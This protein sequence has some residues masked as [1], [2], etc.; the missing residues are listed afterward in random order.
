MT[1]RIPRRQSEAACSAGQEG[2]RTTAPWSS[3]AMCWSIPQR[4]LV[5]DVEVIGPSAPNLH[6][7]SPLEHTDFFVRLCDVEPSGRSL[8]LCDG[9]VRLDAGV[10]ASGTP[11]ALR[12]SRCAS[13]RRRTS[14]GAGTGIRAQVLERRAPRFARNLGGGDPLAT[15][16]TMHVADQEVW[17]DPDH[18][19]AIVLPARDPGSSR[20][21]RDSMRATRAGRDALRLEPTS[22]RR[23]CSWAIPPRGRRHR[24]G[25]LDLAHAR[26]PAR[27]G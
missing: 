15:A 24:A 19:S 4:P 18:P 27:G 9:L 2:R 21:V 25:L 11:T 22:P 12:A 16:V 14:S 1:R 6:V 26:D 20:Q 17:H 7:R 3:A 5:R 10:M 23:G 13:G 8:N